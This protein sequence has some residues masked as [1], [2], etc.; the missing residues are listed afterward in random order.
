M[1]LRV[2]L[3]N[4]STFLAY[5]IANSLFNLL[6]VLEKTVFRTLPY[7]CH[8]RQKVVKIDTNDAD[9]VRCHA[10]EEAF[11]KKAY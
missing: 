10:L 2:F 8:E 9:I 5:T 6:L 3:S 1:A 7:D 11:P 4:G